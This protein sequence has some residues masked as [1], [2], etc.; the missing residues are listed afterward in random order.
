MPGAYGLQ[1]PPAGEGLPPWGAGP[2]AEAGVQSRG[3]PWGSLRKEQCSAWIRSTLV[4]VRS[5]KSSIP[6]AKSVKEAGR[7]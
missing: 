2:G 6:G 3:E 5:R 4:C 7:G 1:F